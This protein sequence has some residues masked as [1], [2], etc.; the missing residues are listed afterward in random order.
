MSLSQSSATTACAIATDP[1]D[2]YAPARFVDRSKL[3]DELGGDDICYICTEF[4]RHPANFSCN[5]TYSVLICIDC[6]NKRYQSW[7]VCAHC[8]TMMEKPQV[9]RALES[10]IDANEVRCCLS[11]FGCTAV[12]PLGNN[13]RNDTEHM[14]QCPYAEE[15]MVCCNTRVPRAQRR[16]HTR[17]NAWGCAI[18]I[19]CPN[20][21]FD[22]DPQTGQLKPVGVLESERLQHLQECPKA[23]VECED[24]HAQLTR[25]QLESHQKNDC[26]CCDLC[27]TVFVDRQQLQAHRM[28]EIINRDR[29]S[30][31]SYIEELQQTILECSQTL[32][33]IIQMQIEL[34]SQTTASQNTR[35]KRQRTAS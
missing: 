15:L 30:Y 6:A 25:E 9:N 11:P 5:C 22:E 23:T 7:P 32:R 12:Y 35:S 29:A 18:R 13:N 21:C 19:R 31:N 8:Q 33:A 28:A 16:S 34:E 1:M 17:A 10:K 20:D 27:D 2:Q 3:V 26:L 24:C 14:Q 4:C